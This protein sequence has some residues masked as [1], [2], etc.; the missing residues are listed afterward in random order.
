M[1]LTDEQLIEAINESQAIIYRTD[2]KRDDFQREAFYAVL[3]EVMDRKRE[4]QDAIQ[5]GNPNFEVNAEGW[6]AGQTY[7]TEI[8]GGPMTVHFTPAPDIP[9]PPPVQGWNFEFNT[10][11][12]DNE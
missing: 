5:L 4:G 9:D 2:L 3:D 7:T 10:D 8:F 12:I 1:A 11:P 6:N